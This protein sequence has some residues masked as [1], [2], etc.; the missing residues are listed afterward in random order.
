VGIFF[1]LK[2]KKSRF[3][4]ASEREPI[5]WNDHLLARLVPAGMKIE[6]DDDV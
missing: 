6:N 5:F 4:P 3:H 1:F 2:R